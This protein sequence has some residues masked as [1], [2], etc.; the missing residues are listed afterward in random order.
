MKYGKCFLIT[1]RLSFWVI[2]LPLI[3][4]AQ[5]T[6]VVQYVQPLSG[7]AASTTPSATKHGAG[8]EKFANTIPAVGHPFG[9]TQWTPQTETSERKCLPPYLYKATSLSGFRG[10]HWLSGSCTQDYGSFAVMPVS[11]SLKTSV[12]DYATP[13]S[14]TD[15]TTQPHYYSVL[16]RAYG[17]KAELTATA[18][19]GMMQ[20]TALKADS[21]Y[22]LITPNSDR[23]KGFVKIDRVRREIYG[24]NPV[25]RLYQGSGKPAG[26]SGYF[27]VR[28]DEA[29]QSAGVFQDSAVS[30]TKD[31]VLNAEKIGAFAGFR[32]EE[33]DRIRLRI[34]TS[35]TSIEAARKNLEAE[36]GTVDFA[37]LAESAKE[38]WQ[39]ALGQV[40]IDDSSEKAKRIFYT[41][42]HHAM[43]HPRLFT[44][45]DGQYP[46]FSKSYKTTRLVKGAYYDDFSMWDVYRA[47]LPLLQILKPSLVNDLVSSLIRK[48]QEGGWLPIFPCWNSYTAAMIGDH[49]TA[50]IASAYAKGIR[51]YDVQEAYRLMRKNAFTVAGDVEYKNGKGRRGMSSYLR[52]GYIPMEDEVLEA[53]HKREQVSRTLEYAFDDY[54][55]ATVAKSLGE[56]TDYEALMKRSRNYQNV[57]DASHNAVR[58]RYAEGGWYVPFNVDRK[59]SFI[60]EGTPRQ[61][62]FSVPHDIT[63]LQKLMGGKAAFERSLD[64]LFEKGEYWH[65]NEPGH[66]IPFLYN[67]TASP[68]KTQQKVSRI[69]AE[70]YGDGPGG[71]S[72]NDDAGQMSAWYVFAAMGFYPV[73]TA[74]N[75]YVL[76]AP[77]FAGLTLLLPNGKR[78]T[79]T[80]VK[81]SANAY[82]IGSVRRNGRPYTKGYITHEDLL[83]GG[84]LEF[85]LQDTPNKEWALGKNDQPN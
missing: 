79:I 6:D 13:F 1:R 44:D 71:I 43:Q 74:S 9:M 17:I 45:V 50:F 64:S 26:F 82:Y 81:S 84:T 77:L 61:Y 16:L 75:Q 78:F 5:K 46:A 12:Q 3:A 80:T 8:T 31:S 2:T 37:L 51:G 48:G 76:C 24:Y 28:F 15:E 33:A 56:T 42:L 73:N 49:S 69:L 14:H 70:E 52:H 41:A 59:E 27:V 18:R 19:C 47:Q 11:G 20:F 58:G 63:G 72:G 85:L 55:L 36:V 32:V 38:V 30:Y 57:F 53:F 22:I 83:K 25:H 39:K 65:G 29:W 54:A 66:H 21:V 4:P 67:Y 62:T 10:S 60:T 40:Q 68:W 35:F 34:G 23:G 7:S